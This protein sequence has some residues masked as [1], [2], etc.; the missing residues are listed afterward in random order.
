M[1]DVLDEAFRNTVKV[2]LHGDEGRNLEQ[3]IDF[4]AR[5]SNPDNLKKVFATQKKMGESEKKKLLENAT[6]L[7]LKILNV[8]LELLQ[9]NPDHIYALTMCRL[10]HSFNLRIAFQK[11]FD[12]PDSPLGVQCKEMLF[13]SERLV[14]E[15]RNVIRDRRMAKELEGSVFNLYIYGELHIRTK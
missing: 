9:A 11:P 10:L 12:E 7:P 5:L 2:I 6:L 13:D 3:A 15:C 4:Y 14:E 1:I 8:L